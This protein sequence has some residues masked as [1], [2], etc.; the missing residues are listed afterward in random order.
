MNYS[1]IKLNDSINGEGISL[2]LFVSG[3][4]NYCKGCFNEDT[5]DFNYGKEFTEETMN[6]ILDNINKN[7]VK[8]NFS[9]LGGDPL[10]DR[11]LR[12][13]LKILGKVKQTYP[14]ITTYVW[15]GYLYEYLL[16]KY[17]E[18]IFKD[19]DVLIDGRFVEELKDLNLKLRGSSNQ[20]IIKIKE[21]QNV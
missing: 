12:T 2:S 3:C 9:V 13:V 15:S 11:N 8:R 16:H 17:G 10:H 21:V 5:W 1:D 19:I 4:T 6:Y 20:R 18:D 7:S 14:T